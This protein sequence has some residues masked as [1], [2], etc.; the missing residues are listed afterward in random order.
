MGIRTIVFAARQ[1]PA[2]L[3]KPQGRSAGPAL[4]SHRAAPRGLPSAVGFSNLG[5]GRLTTGKAGPRLQAWK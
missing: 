5:R 3:E 1:E 2:P 4:P